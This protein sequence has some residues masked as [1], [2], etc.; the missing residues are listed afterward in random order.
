MKIN[1]SING[2]LAKILAADAKTAESAVTA[3]VRKVGDSLKSELRAQIASA[4]LG[5]RL[6][7][8]V[9]SNIYPEKGESLSA[10][11]FVY[12]RPGKG[13]HGGAANIVAAFEDGSLIRANGGTYLAIPTEHVP[14]KS[15]P[16]R[17]MTPAEL[18][19]SVKL[20]GFGQEFKL[21]PTNRPGVVLLVMPVIRSVNGKSLRPA[22]PR[23]L[24]AGQAQEWVA[25]FILV[26]QV[27]MPRLLDCKA[28][29]EQ[30]GSRL[31]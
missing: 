14:M 31:E 24:S 10:A 19:A 13:G 27:Q 21:V 22:T 20:G 15:S 30:W 5:R 17:P 4:G 12:A 23:R 8:A 25:M 26:R 3:A 11:A 29:A 1:V 16:R 2:D 6:A 18:K 28:P 9:R 7:N